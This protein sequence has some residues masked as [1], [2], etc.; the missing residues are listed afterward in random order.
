MMA[1]LGGRRVARGG[2]GGGRGTLAAQRT[3]ARLEDPAP[4]E[5]R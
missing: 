4:A 3:L 2:R 1:A 5:R